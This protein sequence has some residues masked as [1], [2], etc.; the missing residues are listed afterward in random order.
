M[1]SAPDAMASGHAASGGQGARRAARLVLVAGSA[2]SREVPKVLGVTQVGPA[3]LVGLTVADARHHVHIP[4]PTGT[5]KSTLLLRLALGE[6]RAGRGLALLDPQGDL[7]RRL[8]ARLPAECGD[9]LVVIDPDESARSDGSPPSWNVLDPAAFG[10]GRR[11]VELVTEHLVN[12]L[13]GLYAAW[14]GPRLE[15]VLRAACQTLAPYPG[16]TLADVPLLL[17]HPAYRARFTRPL[18]RSDPGGLGGFWDYYDSLTPAQAAQVCGPLLS[19]L[20]AVLGR[21][22]IADLFGNAASSFRM[23]DI[24]DGGILIAR[25][26]KGELGD[27]ACQL[28]G[29]L[30]LAGLWHA[31]T[32]R[33]RTP[34]DA[35]RDASIL[36]DE[37]QN[38]LHLP[39]GIGDALAEA[40]GYRV[41]MVLAHQHLDQLPPRVAAGVDANARNKVMFSLAPGDA[42][43]LSGH[44]VP[45]LT[46]RDLSALDA[47][48]VACRLIV[49]GA[50]ARPFTL[51]TLPA[52]PP[53]AGR[54]RAMRA[55]ARARGLSQQERAASQ[56]RR[57]LATGRVLGGGQVVGFPVSASLSGSLSDSPSV[58]PDSEPDTPDG[59][60]GQ[61]SAPFTLGRGSPT[62][63]Y[64][65]P[66]P[67]KGA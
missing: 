44:T 23:S 14:W 4:G 64:I 32:A 52:P 48:Q 22:F 61:V 8:L 6:A 24:L 54:A 33:A 5:G 1:V 10:G 57:R 41:S 18:K 35:R 17:T 50:E 67:R 63:S 59:A 36:V 51:A 46:E 37:C 42:R 26:P 45:Y 43:R 2:S 16:S 21:A 40:R 11:G 62:D 13:R 20:R 15:D 66:Q 27:D 60:Q 39:I 19:K 38:F 56:A 65:N 25:L 29:S 31:T 53:I 34:P 58:E 30:L 55:A 7:A 47:F 3:Q 12:V 9:R 28:A 49:N